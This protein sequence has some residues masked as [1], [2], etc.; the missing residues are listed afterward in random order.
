MA[1]PI[2]RSEKTVLHR[3]DPNL[4]FAVSVCGKDEV[5]GFALGA[6]THLLSI[7]D[8]GTAKATPLWFKGVHRQI[9]FHDVESRYEA[10]MMNA[11][12]ATREQ[13]AEILRFGDTCRRASLRRP[14]HLLIHCYAG[15]SRSTAACYA[16]VAQTLGPGSA[17]AALDFVLRIRPEAYPNSLVVEYADHFLARNGELVEA[18]QP[19]R[20]AFHDAANAWLAA[21]QEPERPPRK[22]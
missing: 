15:A 14:V 18:L 1:E 13:V 12:M 19:L 3:P 22:K 7:E 10:R 2:H 20:R 4:S 17:V 9:H 16:I 11:T 8:P 21:L 5:D 6:V